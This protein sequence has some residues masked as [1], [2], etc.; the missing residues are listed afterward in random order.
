MTDGLG[1]FC[2][3][4]RHG[5]HWQ[6]R[7]AQ[8]RKSRKA[9]PQTLSSQADVALFCALLCAAI[10]RMIV[11]ACHPIVS[12]HVGLGRARPDCWATRLHHFGPLCKRTGSW[13]PSCRL[14][15]C[16]FPPRL[17]LVFHFMWVA[18]GLII[19]RAWTGGV[20][21]SRNGVGPKDP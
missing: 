5:R 15:P 11:S 4:D 8:A 3:S 18:A 20:V 10:G 21:R 2:V 9:T 6:A 1:A 12:C 13:T 17:P 16:G 7:H 19:S 14:S